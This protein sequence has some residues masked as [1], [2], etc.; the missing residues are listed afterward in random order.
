MF[1]VH[2]FS[3]LRFDNRFISTA[4]LK[5]CATATIFGRFN[6][7][8]ACI[9]ACLCAKTVI[10][11]LLASFQKTITAILAAHT[12]FALVGGSMFNEL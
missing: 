7:S 3:T 8:K 11:L 6:L 12:A 4:V 5:E 9:C 2:F 10:I 1:T